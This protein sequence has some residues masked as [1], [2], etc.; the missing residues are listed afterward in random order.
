MK[1]YLTLL[2]LASS[3]AFAQKE[4]DCYKY[5]TGT[6]YQVEEDEEDT[7]IIERN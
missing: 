7:L 5:F 3:I 6:F 2:L 4:C 1:Y